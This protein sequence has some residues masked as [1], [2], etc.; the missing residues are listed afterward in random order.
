MEEIELQ[1]IIDFERKHFVQDL[2]LCRSPMYIENPYIPAG[3]E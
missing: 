3:P 1:E 2:Y